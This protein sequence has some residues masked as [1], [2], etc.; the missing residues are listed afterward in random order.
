MRRLASLTQKSAFTAAALTLHA[1]LRLSAGIDRPIARFADTPGYENLRFIGS[2]DRFWPVPLVFDLV[3]SDTMRV[4]VHVTVGILAWS[5]LALV[6]SRVS[7]WPLGM[8]CAVLVVGLSPQVIR[9]DLAILSESLGISFT[10]MAVAA[11]VSL[12]RS[13]SNGKRVMWCAVVTLCA[14]TRPV[15]LVILF[16]CAAWCAVRFLRASRIT[17][18]IP[19][20]VLGLLSV[21][22]LALLQGNHPTSMLNFYTVLAERVI[23]DDTRYAWF[24]AHG[25]PDVPGVRQSEGYDFAGALD[26]AL[27]S[28]VSL[29]V[30]QAPPAL[31]RAG[32]IPLAEWVRDDG[33]RTY[34]R[35]ALTH[36]SDS[37]SR[38]SALA[39]PTLS[40]RNDDF[41]P[42]ESRP[43]IPRSIFGDWRIWTLVGLAAMAI[44]L[45]RSTRSSLSTATLAM[46]SLTFVV[47]VAVLFTSGIEHQRHSVT[48]AVMLRVLPL[49][50]LATASAARSVRERDEFVDEP[51]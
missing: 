23:P 38:V 44:S 21:W 43:I 7:R 36:P 35:Y 50:A 27:A 2:V 42:V 28:I 16:A 3:P 34:A 41:L 14:M 40:P 19:T 11:T 39:T 4:A 45:L 10:V 12:A 22:G 46:Y 32:G 5:W 25:M 30:G 13:P 37:W 51:G 15:Q 49:V 26:P 9:Y 6:L 29:P 18:A 24:T 48:V 31:I 47:H 20:V 8:L 1:I 33:W 17:L